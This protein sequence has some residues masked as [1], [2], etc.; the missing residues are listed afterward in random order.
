[1]GAI[2]A[3]SILL[4]SVAVFVGFARADVPYQ[5]GAS[6]ESSRHQGLRLP[7]GTVD[8]AN[9]RSLVASV[10]MLAVGVVSA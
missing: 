1:V 3:G 2:H 7:P 6:N 10:L 8:R 9:S 4:G 5:R